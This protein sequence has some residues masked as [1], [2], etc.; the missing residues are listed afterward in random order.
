MK[1]NIVEAALHKEKINVNPL[2]ESNASSS[3]MIN[4]K[5]IKLDNELSLSAFAPEEESVGISQYIDI[6]LHGKEQLDLENPPFLAIVKQRFSDFIVHEINTNGEVVTLTNTEIP[7][8]IKDKNSLDLELTTEE[9]QLR[10]EQ[11]LTQLS[12]ELSEKEIEEIKIFLKNHEKTENEL[13]EIKNQRKKIEES[14]I[15]TLLIKENNKD[16]RSRIHEIFKQYFG[17]IVITDTFTNPRDNDSDRFVRLRY[18]FQSF[19]LQT[20]FL[21]NQNNSKSKKRQNKGRNNKRNQRE[22]QSNNNTGSSNSGSFFDPR[23]FAWPKD[24]PKYIQFV[25]YKENTETTEV[26]GEMSKILKLKPKNFTIAGTKDKRGITTQLVTGYL[27]SA[28]K[29][30]QVNKNLHNKV[31]K[32]GNFNYVDYPLRLGDLQGN[33]F[34]LVLR[35]IKTR[36]KTK[37]LELI[38]KERIEQINKYGFINYFGMQRFGIIYNRMR[39]EYHQEYP[40]YLLGQHLLKQNWK[41]LADCM[42]LAAQQN[43]RNYKGR[44]AISSFI[45]GKISASECIDSL[46]RFRLH[47]EKV[48]LSGYAKTSA[49][50]HLSAI[51]SLPLNLISMYIHS[52]Q[53]LV[54]NYMTTIRLEKYGLKVVKGDLVVKRIDNGRLPNDCKVTLIESEEQ[55][56]QYTIDDVV[57]TIPGHSVEYPKTEHV[58]KEAFY[59]FMKEHGGVTEQDLI[60]CEFR[61]TGAYRYIIEKAKNIEIEFKEYQ[62]KEERLVLTDLD[63]LEKK[64]IQTTINNENEKKKAAILS[65]SLNSSTYATMFIRELTRIPSVIDWKCMDDEEKEEDNKEESNNTE[66][67]PEE[68]GIINN[69]LEEEDNEILIEESTM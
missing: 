45:E 50:D 61:C 27:I 65:F 43:L 26:I 60:R 1:R 40:T 30:Y 47:A 14:N 28:E 23:Q 29:L 54:F 22:E 38:I 20:L 53:S 41:E 6:L 57:L 3:N 51:R 12:K 7:N 39:G 35:D 59:N 69:G 48:L 18:Q 67:T 33:R 13:I 49:N 9:K 21:N 64:E 24:R 4:E 46:P 58:N 17:H 42:L 10:L 68:E 62:H 25:L 32:V 11:G 8:E 16:K 5:K 63:K 44:E 19:T 15:P 31:V 37:D 66:T 55:A 56:N 34:T 52:Y 36:D 2:S